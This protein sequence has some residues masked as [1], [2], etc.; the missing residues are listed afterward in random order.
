[1]QAIVEGWGASDATGKLELLQGFCSGWPASLPEGPH[2]SFYPWG[3]VPPIV[4]DRG[5][6]AT[7]HMPIIEAAHGGIYSH[8]C[9]IELPAAVWQH[10]SY[11]LWIARACGRLLRRTDCDANGYTDRRIDC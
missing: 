11:L 8:D 3:S 1:M 10:H 2:A 5:A 7:G 4:T 6:A 9:Y